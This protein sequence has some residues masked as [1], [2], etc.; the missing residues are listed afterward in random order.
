MCMQMA[1]AGIQ[2]EEPFSCLPLDKIAHRLR[3]DL[4]EMIEHMK[5]EIM[6]CIL[7]QSVLVGGSV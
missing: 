3:L 5:G 6:S 4:L 1:C 2:I 7:R